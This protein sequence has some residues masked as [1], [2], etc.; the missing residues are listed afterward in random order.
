MTYCDVQ[1]GYNTDNGNMIISIIAEGRYKE[2]SPVPEMADI[3]SSTLMLDS[4][5]DYT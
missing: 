3:F 4:Q 2:E 1:V 5:H